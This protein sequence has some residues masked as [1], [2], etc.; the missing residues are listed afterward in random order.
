[1]LKVK[2]SSYKGKLV[3][4]KS[5]KQKRVGKKSFVKMVLVFRSDFLLYTISFFSDLKKRMPF[6]SGLRVF[7]KVFY[8]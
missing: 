2:V 4:A 8:Y 7:A 5:T 1:M 6:Q 3:L